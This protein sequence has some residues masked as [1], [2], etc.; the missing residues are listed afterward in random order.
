VRSCSACRG[1]DGEVTPLHGW[2]RIAVGLATLLLVGAE[3]ALPMLMLVWLSLLP[4]YQVPSLDALELVSLDSFA[5]V[6][7]S[8]RIVEA[9]FNSLIV[10]I[11]C[12][13]ID[14]ERA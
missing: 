10:G 7:T 8:D 14:R 6:L 2:V 5:R 12:G 1:V 4:F 9:F 3:I 13:F 11:G